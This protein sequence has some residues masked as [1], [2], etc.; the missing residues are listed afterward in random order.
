M[1]EHRRILRAPRVYLRINFIIMRVAGFTIVRNILRF[2]YPFLQSILSALPLCDVFYIGLGQSEDGTEE[3]ITALN[4]EK[5]RILPSIWDDTLQSGGEVLRVETD[6]VLTHIYQ[7]GENFDYLLYLQADELLHEQDLPIIREAMLRELN[8]PKIEGLLFKYHH[9]YGSYAYVGKDKVWYR[10]EVRII[11]NQSEIRSYRDAQGFRK[12]GRKLQVREISAY[13]YHYGW[14]KEPQVQLEKR[15]SFEVL[16]GYNPELL[17]TKIEEQGGYAY[18]KTHTVELF[19]G[20]HPQ[21]MH[22]LVEK[23]SW[24]FRPRAKKNFDK[25]SH[26]LLYYLERWTGKRFFEYKNYKRIKN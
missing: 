9:F 12:A 18:H 19:Q 3:A 10:K 8:N 26:R 6:K 22:E 20:T 1:L 5:I 25:F 2:D 11:K 4:S 23:Q 15:L 17:L 13:I 24:E 14:V 21:L 7:S 16:Y